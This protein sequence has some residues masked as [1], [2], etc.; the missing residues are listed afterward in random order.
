MSEKRYFKLF[1]NRT[2]NAI[3]RKNY[4]Q[5]FDCIGNLTVYD[6]KELQA[7]LDAAKL[8]TH[9]IA[10]DKN[11]LYQLV[12]RSLGDYHTNNSSS[13]KVKNFIA[14]AE[15]LYSKALYKQCLLQLK[16]AE[17]LAKSFDLFALQ[18]EIMRW[19]RKAKG[20]TLDYLK[21]STDSSFGAFDEVLTQLTNYD[22]YNDLY[23]KAMYLRKKRNKIRNTAAIKEFDEL[24]AYPLLSDDCKALSKAAKIRYYEIYASYYYSIDDKIKEYACNKK[25]LEIMRSDLVYLKEYIQNYIAVYSRLLY[26]QS[27]IEPHLFNETLARFRA[28]PQEIGQVKI[29]LQAQIFVLS[30]GVAFNTLIRSNKFSQALTLVPSVEKGLLQYQDYIVEEYRMNLYYRF[31]YAYIVV[32]DYNN[33]LNYINTILNDFSETV[34]PDVF[35]F[36]KIMQVIAHYELGN[37]KLLPYLISGTH[38]FLKKRKRLHKAEKLLLKFF[39][40]LVRQNRLHEKNEDLW[41]DLYLKFKAIVENPL[42]QRMLNYFDLLSWIE[43]KKKRKTMLTIIRTRSNQEKQQLILD[44][45]VLSLPKNLDD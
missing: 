42:E 19:E 14:Y 10:S 38:T 32:A 5:L 40:R 25:L 29:P 8:P 36:A 23:Y 44:E 12:L 15:I 22:A 9:H 30:Y 16:K 34:R 43:G 45:E 28:I 18:L 1:A 13:L 31:A 4:V 21:I 26:S 35:D 17:K 6:E 41:N 24:M 39:Q 3:K 33:G 11:Y 37:Y 20:A 2:N 27:F 7:A